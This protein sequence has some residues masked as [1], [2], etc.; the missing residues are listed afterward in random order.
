MID[1]LD[2]HQI[3][4][5]DIETVSEVRSFDELSDTFKSLWSAKS[6]QVLKLSNAEELS[7]QMLLE[8]YTSRAAIFAEFGKIVCI[9]VGFVALVNGK[10]VAKFKSF[11]GTDEK[12]LLSDFVHLL[13]KHYDHPEKQF[14]CGHNVKEFDVPYMPTIDDSSAGV[15]KN[16]ESARQKTM[17]NQ[18]PAGHDGALEIW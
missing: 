7:E 2:I 16:V 3:L 4:F 13:N 10:R 8:S 9:S 1:Q 5:L 14:L 11:S 18:A 15:S 6:R 12:Q 17:G